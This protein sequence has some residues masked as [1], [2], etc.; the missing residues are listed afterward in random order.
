M[1]LSII[2]ENDDI[3]I[4]NKPSGLPCHSKNDGDD[5]RHLLAKAAE[6]YPKIISEFLG[7]IDGGL[8]HRLD[9][10]TSGLVLIAK[11]KTAKQKYQ[12]MVQDGRIGKIYRGL[13]VGNF[14]GDMEIKWPIAH[15][16]KSK[17]KMVVV[18]TKSTRHRGTPRPCCSMMRSVNQEEKN[19]RVEIQLVGPGARHQI[20]VH[21]A[22]AGYPLVG[23]MLYGKAMKEA[24]SGNKTR[25]LLHAHTL[26]IP[27][28][29]TFT[30]E[31]PF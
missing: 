14:E 28:L 6:T 19:T 3:L 29:G 27:G 12:Q 10:D 17:K 30:V 7:E 25:H 4:L 22:K 23:D 2:F 20:R 11:N 21:L 5:S 8:C 26:D 15:H 13:V 31:E 9:N 16:P 24:L 18:D 1:K